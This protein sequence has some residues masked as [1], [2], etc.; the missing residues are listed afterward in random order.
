MNIGS[1]T[2]Q[3]HS[4]SDNGQITVDLG[5]KKELNFET[6]LLLLRDILDEVHQWDW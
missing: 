1:A 6:L 3:G 2:L 5:H 4:N